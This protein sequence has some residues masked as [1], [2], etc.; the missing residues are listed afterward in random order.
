M[1]IR[2][3]ITDPIDIINFGKY[4]GKTIEFIIQNNPYY[5][6]WLDDNKIVSFSQNIIDSAIMEEINNSPPESF[7]WQPD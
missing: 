5:I 7:F 3:V 2:Q 1:A 6:F 4:S